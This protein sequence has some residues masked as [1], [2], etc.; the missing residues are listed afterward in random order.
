MGCMTGILVRPDD[1]K[2]PDC[3]GIGIWNHKLRK[4]E[5][6]PISEGIVTVVHAH[7]SVTWSFIA[8]HLESRSTHKFRFTTGYILYMI[9]N[10]SEWQQRI[11]S[12]QSNCLPPCEFAEI[13]HSSSFVRYPA[14]AHLEKI[15]TDLREHYDKNLTSDQVYIQ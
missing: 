12:C 6:Q 4:L 10:S 11:A 9:I 7:H 15:R 1:S 3:G 5:A 14:E 13:K 8:N 2:Y